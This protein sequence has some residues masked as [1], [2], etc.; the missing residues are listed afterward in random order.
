MST[1]TEATIAD[2][3]HLELRDQLETA[4]RRANRLDRAAAVKRRNV[5]AYVNRL[6]ATQ[7]SPDL[8]KRL[9]NAYMES[10]TLKVRAAKMRQSAAER[11][12]HAGL[13]SEDGSVQ[14]LSATLLASSP[15]LKPS[16]LLSGARIG[17]LSAPNAVSRANLM[18]RLRSGVKLFA[19][20][21]GTVSG[22]LTGGITLD[23]QLYPPVPILRRKLRLLDL[24][25]IGQTDSEAVVYAQQTT[26]TSAA[27]ETALGTA[28]GEAN[29]VF[30]KVTAPVRSVGSFTTAYRE[31]VADAAQFQ[32]VITEQLSEDTMLRLETEVYAGNGS[33]ENLQGILNTPNIANVRRNYT[34][35]ERI[36][37][38]VHRGI[39]TVRLAFREP[40]AV[41]L[42]PTDLEAMLFEKTGSDSLGNYVF[43]GALTNLSGNTPASV[44]GLPIVASPVAT[45]GTGMVACWSDATLW[46]RSGIDIRISDSHDDYFTRRQLAILADIRA[47][48]SV[49]RPQTFCELS[50]LQD[51]S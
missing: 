39:T 21:T 13:I 5:D 33:G 31:Q 46:M 10:D 29:F 15:Q 37:E 2:R 16:V 43:L 42:H 30:S 26:R 41:L 47:A 9:S 48:F 28:Y 8:V 7:A 20:T 40:T 44:W 36:I 49:Q 6:G 23:Q 11:A 18:S 38:L 17:D 1:S 24:V 51:V 45:Q 22:D 19:D 35:G 12:K 3:R 4:V 25:T 32:T 27:A 14:G 50:N 34:S